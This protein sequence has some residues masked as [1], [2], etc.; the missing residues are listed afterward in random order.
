MTAANMFTAIANSHH[1]D[2]NFS[3]FFYLIHNIYVI[4]RVYAVTI[5]QSKI[6]CRVPDCFV[7]LHLLHVMQHV[8]SL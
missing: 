4:Q 3:F 2:V 5:S 8:T 1:N 6:Y 7:W